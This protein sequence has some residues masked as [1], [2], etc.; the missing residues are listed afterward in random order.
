MP[1]K[2]IDLFEMLEQSLLILYITFTNPLKQRFP[3]LFSYFQHKV[4]FMRVTW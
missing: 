3:N 2:L 1:A 4:L